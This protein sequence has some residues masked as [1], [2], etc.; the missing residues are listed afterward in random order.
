M[1]ETPWND[2]VKQEREL[3]PKELTMIMIQGKV[4]RKKKKHGG[5]Q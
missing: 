5:A 2:T 3:T 1:L 4:K